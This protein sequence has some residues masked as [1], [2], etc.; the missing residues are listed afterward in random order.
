MATR[1]EIKNYYLELRQNFENNSPIFQYNKDRAHNS[2]V[3]RLMLDTSTSI[4]MY[5]GQMSVI[6]TDFYEHIKKE[7]ADLA[8]KLLSELQ[9]SFEKFITKDGNKLTIIL[10]TYKDEYLQDLICGDDFKRGLKNGKIELLKLNDKLTFK[11]QLY[12]FS[13]SDTMIVRIEQ[14]KEQ[15]SAVCSLNQKNIYDSANN[16]F[17]NIEAI[18]EKVV[19]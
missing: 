4:K 19:C 13:L 8:E 9:E 16:V 14:D 10:E 18:A 5:C 7:D 12:H 15:H 6:R 2:V 3:L 1:E 11:H 17:N